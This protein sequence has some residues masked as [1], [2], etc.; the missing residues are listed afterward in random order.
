MKKYIYLA[1]TL[2]TFSLA[3]CEDVLDDINRKPDNPSNEAISPSLQLPDGIM[4]T[5]YNAVS[6]DMSFYVSSY[7][8]Q[9]V[10]VGANQLYN[11]EIRNVSSVASS[12][13]FNNAWNGTYGNILNLKLALAKCE[14]D[15]KYY[16]EVDV[17]GMIKTLLALNYGVM[18]DM[19]GDIPCSEAGITSIKQPKVDTQESVYT[20][21]FRLLDGAIAD[22]NTASEESIATAG[23]HD[24]L[25]G[26]DVEKWEAFA[27]ALIARYKLHLMHVD[28]GAAD[29]ALAAAEMAKSL[30]FDGADITGFSSYASGSCNPWAAFWGDRQYNAASKTVNDIMLERND[31]RQPVYMTPWMYVGNEVLADEAA[32]PGSVEDARTVYGTSAGEGFAIPVWLNVYSYPNSEAASIHL[33]SKA[34]LYFILAELKVRNGASY[35]EDFLAAVEASFADYGS[36]GIALNMSATDYVASLASRLQENSLKEVMV[37]KYLSQCRDEHLETYND[38]RRMEALGNADDYVQKTNSYNT[39]GGANRWPLRLPYGNSDVVANP[40]VSDLYG[41]GM[42]V[43]TEKIWWAGGTR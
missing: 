33:F 6:G 4:A 16:T 41:D 35:S 27:Y 30:G 14:D 5:G 28:A 29:E 24:L 2:L 13:T 39:Q 18:T 7:T 10:G 37:Q 31:P 22:F 42:Y 20:E 21:I 23:T 34:E 19:F 15:G 32:V 17:R 9:L 43:F 40:N 38:F 12:G 11:A 3:S 1:L 36:F 26:G 25:Y 8:E